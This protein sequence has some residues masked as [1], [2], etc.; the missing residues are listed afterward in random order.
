MGPQELGS[1][2]KHVKSTTPKLH[3]SFIS[4]LIGQNVVTLSYLIARE[5]GKC[6]LYSCYT[7]LTDTQGF[8]KKQPRM[9]IG[10]NQLSQSQ[11]GVQNT[12]R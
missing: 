7:V 5:T 3:V 4:Y 11:L 8:Q 6:G 1:L 12:T 9:G 2:P 10:D